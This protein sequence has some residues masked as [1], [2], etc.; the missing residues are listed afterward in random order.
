[1]DLP[2]LNSMQATS[3]TEA[4]Q[5]SLNIGT[6]Y[7]SWD[8]QKRLGPQHKD[9]SKLMAFRQR[10]QLTALNSWNA[11]H[12]PT[13]VNEPA[14]SRIDHFLMRLADTD[15]MA[16]DVKFFPAAAF[17]PLTGARH[18]PM[19]CSIRKIPYSFSKVAK[20]TQCTF[21]QRMHCRQ[22]WVSDTDQWQ[23]F[24][25]QFGSCFA[26]FMQR[27]HQDET[28]IDELHQQLMPTFHQLFP[29]KRCGQ[30]DRTHDLNQHCNIIRTNWF[31]RE[32]F[33]T[34]HGT[35][36]GT[37]SLAWFHVCCF[38]ALKRE[39]QRFGRAL[40]KQ[41]LCELME[42]VAHASMRHDSFSVYQA[43]QKY[44]PKQPKKRIRLRLPTGAPASPEE[45]LDMTKEYTREI[46]Q[47]VKLFWILVTLQGC[48]FPWMSLLKN[49]R[50]SRLPRQ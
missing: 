49:Y 29:S 41:R 48:H 22:A 5:N 13:F 36:T 18:I 19:I 7:H 34:C 2:A 30:D 3:R 8:T 33:L 15:S 46:W 50:K 47:P 37:F 4:M 31:H 39:Q 25:S 27:P 12:P 16:K 44:T 1:M 20:Q 14:T 6:S 26:Q 23:P 35:D 40:K 43:V 24:H 9:M 21:Q 38:T 32:K 11:Q 10:Y 42:E 45:V 17:L 28:L